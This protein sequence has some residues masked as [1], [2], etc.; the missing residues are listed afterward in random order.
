[1]IYPLKRKHIEFYISAVLKD[2]RKG[3]SIEVF[4]HY[5]DIRKSDWDCFAS[6]H[7]DI[8]R[9]MNDAHEFCKAVALTKVNKMMRNKDINGTV[10][11]MYLQNVAGW[12]SASDL[13]DKAPPTVI[14]QYG[15]TTEQ[16]KAEEKERRKK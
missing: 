3:N 14:I 4:L 5:H 16:L 7:K 6:K 13:S 9:A 2:G 1:M 12:G 8:R 10:A 15:K 11:K